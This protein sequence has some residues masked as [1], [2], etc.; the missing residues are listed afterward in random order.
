MMQD[1]SHSLEFPTATTQIPKIN[2]NRSF[3]RE[4]KSGKIE[5]KGT[6]LNKRLSKSKFPS[7]FA[8]AIEGVQNIQ[9]R[10]Q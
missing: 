7:S 5:M 1:W 8:T 3:W 4:K 9:T 10:K 6:K 2:F